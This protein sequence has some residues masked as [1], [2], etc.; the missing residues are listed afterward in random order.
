MMTAIMPMAFP[1]GSFWP[2]S[3]STLLGSLNLEPNSFVSWFLNEIRP[4][5][6][7]GLSDGLKVRAALPGLIGSTD[8]LTVVP[9]GST[10]FSF[11][12]ALRFLPRKRVSN[13]L[14]SGQ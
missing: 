3:N 1:M 13:I 8:I 14:E 7:R 2:I 11:R 6:V 9:S 10:A 5:L 12:E 4:D